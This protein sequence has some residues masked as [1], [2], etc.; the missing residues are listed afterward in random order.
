M[1]ED[2]LGAPKRNYGWYVRV[3]DVARLISHLSPLFE[4]R[5]AGSE[6]SGWSGD[7]KISFYGDGVRMSFDSGK[8]ESVNSIGFVERHEATAHY[9]DLTFLRALFGQQSFTQLRD[10]YHDCYVNDFAMGTL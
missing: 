5:L 3:P 7:V 8:L 10:S 2:P 4:K 9:P 6:M 1:Y